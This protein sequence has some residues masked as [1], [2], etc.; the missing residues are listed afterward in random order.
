MPELPEVETIIRSLQTNV[1]ANINNIEI[2]RE[3]ILRLEEFPAS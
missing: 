3:D 2:R 1:G